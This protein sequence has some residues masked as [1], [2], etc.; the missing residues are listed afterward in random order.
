MEVTLHGMEPRTGVPCRTPNDCHHAWYGTRTGAP[1]RTLNDW[2]P[3]WWII[4]TMIIWSEFTGDGNQ[5]AW[6]KPMATHLT[7]VPSI[8]ISLCEFDTISWLSER[9]VPLTSLSLS[10][11]IRSSTSYK[12]D[13]LGT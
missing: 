4:S 11:L 2:A 9:V 10:F 6:K 13:G 8:Y 1:C 7:H 12:L 5:F 3:T